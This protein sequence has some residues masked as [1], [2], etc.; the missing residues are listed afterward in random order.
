MYEIIDSVPIVVLVPLFQ[1]QWGLVVGLLN[2]FLRLGSVMNFVITPI[3]YNARGVK[4]ALWFATAVAS[5]TILSAGAIFLSRNNGNGYDQLNVSSHEG[6]NDTTSCDITYATIIAKADSTAS[7]ACSSDSESDSLSPDMTSYNMKNTND[8]DH[9]ITNK[10]K[11][12]DEETL[13]LFEQTDSAH[14][15]EIVGSE[16]IV[17]CGEEKTVSKVSMLSAAAAVMSKLAIVLP[18]HLFQYQYYMFLLSGAFLYGSMVPFWFLGSKFLQDHYSLTVG[19]ADALMLFPE[20]MIAIVSVPI[21]YLLDLSKCN[22]K[23]RLKLLSV[24]CL[25]LPISYT[26]LAYGFY[27][28]S[29]SPASSSNTDSMGGPRILH[30][31]IPPLVTMCAIGLAYAVSNSLYWST[32]MDILPKGDHFSAANG[33]I[34]SCL[35]VLPSFVPPFLIFAA[36]FNK[37][38]DREDAVALL[39]LHLLSALGCCA[40]LF[41]FLATLERKS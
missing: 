37:E 22:T 28:T 11:T 20:G 9:N 36:S 6:P 5:S 32:V 17:D 10:E 34:A 25:F 35:N 33:L 26:M 27:S 7:T 15:L 41:S 24:A 2:G 12:N 29:E 38:G 1:S 31:S 18:L 21:G 13:I 30:T 4:D 39:P 8:S 3:I 16:D 23:S 40:S 19:R 14:F